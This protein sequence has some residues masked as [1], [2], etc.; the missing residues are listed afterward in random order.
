[1]EYKKEKVRNQVIKGGLKKSIINRINSNENL[2]SNIN[3]EIEEK[4]D[5]DVE[6]ENFNKIF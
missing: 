2:Y 4:L 5:S 1:M 6:I 3:N